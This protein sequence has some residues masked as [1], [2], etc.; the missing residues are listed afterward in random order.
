MG[1]HSFANASHRHRL[2]VINY[3]NIAHQNTKKKKIPPISL[4]YNIPFLIY[5]NMVKIEKSKLFLFYFSPKLRNHNYF[6]SFLTYHSQQQLSPNSTNWVRF[7]LLFPRQQTKGVMSNPTNFGNKMKVEL[8]VKEKKKWTNLINSSLVF[9]RGICAPVER[10]NC[11]KKLCFDGFGVSDIG[12]EGGEE[13]D[14]GAPFVWEERDWWRCFVWVGKRG[15]RARN[16]AGN[17][18]VCEER[19]WR[20][21]ERRWGLCGLMS[22]KMKPW[23]LRFAVGEIWFWTF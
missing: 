15:C 20:K 19:E 3:V 6:F 7:K 2:L 12:E 23:K 16:D 17:G 10:L 18:G 5:P 14:L 13:R 1:R 8:R 9:R 4:S 21:R 11:L 22:E